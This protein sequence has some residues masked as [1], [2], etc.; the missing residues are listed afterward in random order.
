M[1]ERDRRASLLRH[2]PSLRVGAWTPSDIQDTVALLLLRPCSFGSEGGRGNV[3]R[4]ATITALLVVAL[5]AAPVASA[6][7]QADGGLQISD[8]GVGKPPPG[9]G[10]GTKAA[11]D[12]PKCD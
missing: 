9:A 4:V 7:T 5:M 3:R 8:K 10:M 6:G 1:G 2:E 11:L 12:N